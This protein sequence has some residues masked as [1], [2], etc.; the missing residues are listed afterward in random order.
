MNLLILLV[1]II[2]IAIL[3]GVFYKYKLGG[4][5]RDELIDQ[6]CAKTGWVRGKNYYIHHKDYISGDPRYNALVNRTLNCEDI[7]KTNTYGVKMY[8]RCLNSIRN[9]DNI[10]RLY[11]YYNT[12]HSGAIFE[13]TDFGYFYLL[14]LKLADVDRY[15]KICFYNNDNHIIYVTTQKHE[16]VNSI[17]GLIDLLN[18]NREEF[19]QNS[20]KPI[21]RPD[22]N[23]N[24]AAD[25]GPDTNL[26]ELPE[27]FEDDP[28]S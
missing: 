22:T 16:K 18:I 23:T 7:D 21:F 2:V 4:D 12:K 5:K 13:C 9:L 19:Y 10:Y 25:A 24:T 15:A 14:M 26:Y 1:V 20:S 27:N 8:D 6:I 11:D 3:I 28:L 17:D